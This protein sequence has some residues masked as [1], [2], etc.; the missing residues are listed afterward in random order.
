MTKVKLSDYVADRLS[1]KY[2]VEH[3]FLV[4]GGGAMHLNDSLGRKLTYTASHH[5][6]ASAIA[7]EGYSRIAKRLSVVN[8]TTGPGGMNTMNGVFGQWT[9]CVPVLYLSGQVKFE[10][11]MKSCTDINL[12]QLG[13]QEVD[14]VSCVKPIT[15][16]AVMITDPKTIKY[17]LDRAVFEAT[18]GKMGPVWLDIPVDIQA[19]LIDEN[20][21]ESFVPPAPIEYSYDI[22]TIIRKL[23]EAKR[24][25][26][27][28]GYG[29]RLSNQEQTFYKLLKKI[30]IPVVTTFNNFDILADNH[31]NYIGRIGT[32]GQRGANFALQSADLILCLGTRNNITQISYNYKNFAKQAYKI[33]VD[34]D[35]AELDKPTVIPD[36]KV[37]ADLK[38]FLP[39]LNERLIVTSNSYLEW[40]D[41]CLERKDKYS[42]GHESFTEDNEI[43]PYHF[44]YELTRN[45][46]NDDIFVM[47]NG[48]ACVCPYQTAV[49][50]NGQRYLLNAGNVSMGYELPAAIGAS[51]AR[52]GKEV[53]CLAGDGSIMMNLQE[54]QTVKHYNLPIKI[55]IISNDGYISI[56]QTQDNLF[57]GNMVGSGRS[58]GVSCPD[59]AAVGT[60]FGIKS[61]VLDS[62]KMMK[63][64]IQKV[65]QINEPVLC[66]VKTKTDY[67]FAPKLSARKLDDGTII[68]PGLEDMFPFLSRDEIMENTINC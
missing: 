40:L 31:K 26:I 38:Q 7:A 3:F 10:T 43:C 45:M 54:L 56:K 29:I 63:S 22:D 25:L 19:A 35:K 6:Q 33:V 4:S 8:V 62:P 67:I 47:A 37:L 41:W 39:E 27:I 48:T 42:F 66:E 14:I 20:E 2:G 58:S 52:G 21:L 50:K 65:F 17:H 24:P 44:T 34:I 16:Y 1:K 32:V 15:K 61:I 57:G 12:R 64:E 49:V 55:F 5:E 51:I 28:A 36:M 13:D 53:V 23:S 9:D 60:A 59:F 30:D 68:S 18:T 46:K 11:C